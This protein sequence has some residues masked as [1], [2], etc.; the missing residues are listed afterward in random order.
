M[1]SNVSAGAPALAPEIISGAAG[2]VGGISW[3][4]AVRHRIP[5]RLMLLLLALPWGEV[6]AAEP[7]LDDESCLVCHKYPMLRGLT[8]QGTERSYYVGPEVFS[9]TVHRNVPCRDCHKEIK[10]LPHDPV[11]EGVR[12]DSECHA[13]NNPATGRPFSHKVIYDTYRKSVHGRDKGSGGLTPYCTDCHSNPLYNPAQ[14]APPEEVIKRCVVCHEERGFVVRWYNHT[15]RRVL[16]VQR[17][18]EEV[19]SLCASCHADETVIEKAVEK[20][21]SEGRKLGRKFPH[22]VESYQESFHGKMT[23]LGLAAAANCLDCHA[24]RDHYF[25]GVHNIRPSRDPASPVSSE[26]RLETCRRCHK[27][28]NA[29]YALLDPHPTSE[30]QGD[31][32]RYWAELIYGIIGDLVIVGLVG[33]SLFE[34]VG[35]RRD[36]VAWRLVNGTS[37]RRPSSR[38]RE[39]VVD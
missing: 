30:R 16:G 18:G 33:V 37:W 26:K 7:F 17:Y 35:R 1:T 2:P 23:G 31:P 32:F 21:A 3:R 12:C 27:N 36:G 25:L 39:R 22:A 4:P 14:Q 19:V 28:A 10:A 6:L 29:K 24:D 11:K 20:A 34:T 15:S 38:G 5:I 13:I 9:R 8:A